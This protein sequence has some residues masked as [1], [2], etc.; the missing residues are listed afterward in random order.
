MITSAEHWKHHRIIDC[1]WENFQW[2]FRECMGD[3]YGEITERAPLALG[4]CP[5]PLPLSSGKWYVEYYTDQDFVCVQDCQGEFPCNGR[6]SSYKELYDTFID[7]CTI[8]TWWDVNC[9]N[10]NENGTKLESEPELTSKWYV[11]YY[12]DA[13]PLCVRECEGPNCNGRA[14]NYEELY[15]TFDECCQMHLW[16]NTDCMAYDEHGNGTN[17]LLEPPNT[18][19]ADYLSGS[20]L[21]DCESGPLGCAIAPPPI[22]L[23]NTIKEC[24]DFG[25]SWVDS[26]YC[27]SRS[28]G[29]YS[30]GWIISS[31]YGKCAKDCDPTGGPPCSGSDLQHHKFSDTIFDTP[32]EC[33][34]TLSWIDLDSCVTASQTGAS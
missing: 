9:A 12:T 34:R 24:C 20:C 17:G 5:D 33:C 7:C 26:K 23:Y 4:P 30:N 11:E 21:K 8:H 3:V 1:C 19:Y 31:D 2:V 14:V 29:E 6:A 32:N 28:N 16:W 15:D 10:Y 18:Y 22:A 25:Q 13:K 27:N